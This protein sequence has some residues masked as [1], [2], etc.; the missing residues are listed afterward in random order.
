MHDDRHW[1]A[2]G[3]NGTVYITIDGGLSWE[4]EESGTRLNLGAVFF[5]DAN[6]GFV[7]GQGGTILR[8]SG[9][10]CFYPLAAGP[11]TGPDH[12][13]QGSGNMLFSIDPVLHATGYNW[14]YSGT[15]IAIGNGE[16]NAIDI[17]FSQDATSGVLTVSGKSMCGSGAPSSHSVTVNP[18]SYTTEKVTICPG[19]EY[20]GITQP[21][22]WHRN[23]R[24]SVGCDS[25][26]ITILSNH[27]G[28]DPGVVV[29]G[30]TLESVG[31]FPSFQIGRASCRE[32]V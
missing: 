31:L 27:P 1:V 18:V 9:E 4:R 22:T 14:S 11:V 5:I 7:T 32:R 23:F 25:T 12:A 30:D 17:S 15:G 24:S 3:T 16:S 21:G 20:H 28:I 26:V 10:P 29:R 19:E 8:K 13:C 2:T 6:N